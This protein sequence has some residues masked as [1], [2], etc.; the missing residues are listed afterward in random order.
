MLA[1]VISETHQYSIRDILETR[2]HPLHGRIFILSYGE[3][4]SLPR[5]PRATWLFLDIERLTADELTGS[6]RRLD[7]L[8]DISP[9]LLVLNRPDRIASR[10]DVMARLHETGIN[11]F[12][13]LPV[14]TPAQTLRFPVFLRGVQ[15]HEGPK[16]QLLYTPDELTQAIAALPHPEGYGVTEYVDARNPDGLYE[17]RSYMRLGNYLFPSALDTSRHWVCKGEHRDPATVSQPERELAFLSGQEDYETLQRA[18][19]ITG[20]DYGRA[21][22]GII[23]GRPQIFEINTNPW[24]EPPESVPAE[25]RKGAECMVSR[26]LDGLI[27]LDQDS[28]IISPEWITVPGAQPGPPHRMNRRGIV[29][30]ILHHL[31]WLHQ[32]TRHM[33]RLR[34]MRLI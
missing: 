18:F 16:S 32:E 22:Y 1:F 9:G 11:S 31:N 25:S 15:D 30:R 33:R 26:Y 17:K 13:L 23:D 14:N 5:L 20:I 19:E 10:M 7:M 34:N 12:R 28:G 6:I 27:A 8:L 21:D 29:H 4:L 24:L 2:N 3:F